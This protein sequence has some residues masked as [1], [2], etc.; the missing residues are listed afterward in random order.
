MTAWI[1]VNRQ[2]AKGLKFINSCIDR[3]TNHWIE[4]LINDYRLKMN[5]LL[6]GIYMD[7]RIYIDGWTDRLINN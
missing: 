1:A 3:C 6:D 4:Q 7:A 5:I 2:I